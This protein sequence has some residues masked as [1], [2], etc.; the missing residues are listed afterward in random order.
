[1]PD[2]QVWMRRHEGAVQGWETPLER[3]AIGALQADRLGYAFASGYRE[4]LRALL[5]EVGDARL[6]FCAT[7]EGPAAPRHM[8]TRLTER[9]VEQGGGWVLDGHKRWTTMGSL[10]DELLVFAVQGVDE[11]GRN[12]LA[13]V[14][15]PADR[16]GV[17]V[18]P[19]EATPFVPEIPHAQC[20]FEGVE[21][22]PDERLPGDAYVRYLKP[23]RTVEDLHVHAAFLGWVI[24][25]A[26]RRRWPTGL[27]ERGTALLCASWSLCTA[28]P[29][30][31][32]THVVLAG[33]IEQ[34]RALAEACPWPTDGHWERDRRLLD[35]AGRARAART[36]AAWRR[37]GGGGAR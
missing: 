13:L 28:A 5:P 33:I 31:P 20:R 10:A 37:L 23:F 29:L 35:V 14:R 21:V 34:T 12:S 25:E 6:G 24:G 3:A 16:R 11:Q 4:A 22:A 1:M 26:R 27:M 17:R 2:L 19:G 9:S 8:R 30:A 32:A 36:E 7:E 15:V 18:E